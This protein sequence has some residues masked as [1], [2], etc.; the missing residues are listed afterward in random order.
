MA[1]PQEPHGIFESGGGP[2]HADV[3]YV[4][5]VSQRAVVRLSGDTASVAQAAVAEEVP[6]AFVYNRRPHVVMMATPAD[7]ED[8]A[9][10]FTVTEEIAAPHDIT[11]IEVARYSRGIELSI[12]IPSEA[13]ERLEQRARAISGRTGCGL[14]GVEAIEDAVRAPR[15]VTATFSV[16]PDALWRAGRAL[17]A[18]QLLNRQTHAIHAAAWSTPDGVL[19]IVR[20]DVGRHNAL[21]KTLGALVKGAL[22]PTTGFLVL[23]SRA[24]FE[25]VQKAAVCG[26]S[27]LAAVSR[28][29][30]LAVTMADAAGMTLVGLLRGESANLYTHAYRIADGA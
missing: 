19:H 25:L 29:T 23:T 4:P 26:V 15:V 2:R 24:S 16:T 13:G 8:L 7:L 30:G 5:P 18:L 17:D 20:E 22:D 12:E 10:G 6:V 11:R 14:C 28:P 27:L 1:A 9:V 21:D 3:G